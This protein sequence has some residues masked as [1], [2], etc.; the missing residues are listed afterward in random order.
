MR[1]RTIEQKL[2]EAV[3]SVG[4]LAPK[5]ASPGLVGVPDRIVLLP[6]GKMAFVEVKTRG[7][8]L[9][10]VQNLR[11]RQLELLGYKVFVLDDT[12]EIKDLLKSIQGGDAR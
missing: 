3:R 10:P 12:R 1:E 5:F 8:K 2:V 9:R 7:G 11:K 4:G 6:D